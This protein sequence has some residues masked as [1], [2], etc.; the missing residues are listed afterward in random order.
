MDEVV[1]SKTDVENFNKPIPALAPREWR[2]EKDLQAL[3]NLPKVNESE[4][5]S[6]SSNK[7]F[8]NRPSERLYRE[9]EAGEVI[10]KFGDKEIKTVLLQGEGGAG[11]STT[12][13]ETKHILD[14]QNIPNIIFSPKE[15]NQ[16]LEFYNM[17]D[18]QFEEMLNGL[19]EYS[20]SSNAE[21]IVL[22]DSG[23]YMFQ[24]LPRDKRKNY[25]YYKKMQDL[26]TTLEKPQF[27]VITTWHTDWDPRS[28]RDKILFEQWRELFPESAQFDIKDTVSPSIGVDMIIDQNKI[29]LDKSNASEEKGMLYV[30]AGR[31]NT[32]QL[33]K[34][35][36]DQFQQI[37][38]QLSN[39]KVGEWEEKIDEWVKTLK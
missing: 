33:K 24:P 35:T 19:N 13:L 17:V 18:S 30:I 15:W 29:E 21:L 7:A 38:S 27:K 10:K 5:S 31:L 6:W 25:E 20:N 8:E 39:T 26:M 14:E 23:D 2:S 3:D 16:K 34:L 9:K 4:F 37:K 28:T 32:N 36:N 22:I 12:I 1:E 11:K